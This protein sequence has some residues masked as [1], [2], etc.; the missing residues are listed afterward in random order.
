MIFQFILQFFK[1]S[2][3]IL[4]VNL[5]D[6]FFYPFIFLSILYGRIFGWLTYQ[7]VLNYA[8]ILLNYEI[9]ARSTKSINN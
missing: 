8:R 9:R 6:L 1:L 5:F 3:K 2:S 4:K 7:F